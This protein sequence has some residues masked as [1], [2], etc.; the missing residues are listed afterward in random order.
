M[1]KRTNNNF[2]APVLGVDPISKGTFV[3]KYAYLIFEDDWEDDIINGCDTGSGSEKFASKIVITSE[4]DNPLFKIAK[5][6]PLRLQGLIAAVNFGIEKRFI[7]IQ[8]ISNYDIYPEM[9]GIEQIDLNPVTFE[10]LDNL[11]YM[12]AVVNYKDNNL[13]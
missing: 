10:V 7:K 5:E 3:I 8:S 9:N 12:E 1:S 13:L 11:E 4:N 2:D 6:R